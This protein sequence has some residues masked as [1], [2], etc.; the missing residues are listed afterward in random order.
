[1]KKENIKMEIPKKIKI[2]EK[3]YKVYEKRYYFNDSLGG[4]INYNLN[5]LGI[6]KNLDDRDKQVTFFHEVSHGILKELEFNHPKITTFRNNEDFVQEMG[7]ILRK[8]F[9]D[10]L[11]KQK[12]K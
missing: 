9:L 2:G 11:K 1:M 5:T 8:M 10:L 4:Q 7:L 12:I 3:E 6:R